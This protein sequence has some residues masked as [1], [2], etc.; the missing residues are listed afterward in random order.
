MRACI[1]ADEP[2]TLAGAREAAAEAGR[3]GL[4][5]ESA[6]DDGSRLEAGASILVFTGTPA[7]VAAAEESLIGLMAK[8]SG[9][10]T[11]AA[12]FV[13]RAGG[14]PEVVSGAWKKMPPAEKESVRRAVLLGGARFRICREPFVYL[15]KNYVEMLGGIRKSL[16]ATAGLGG[17]TRVIQLKGRYASIAEEACLAAESGADILSVD[18]GRLPDVELAA[19]A[20][21][22]RGLRGRVRIAFANGVRLAEMDAIKASDIDI[23]DVGREIVD[24]PLLDMRMEVLSVEAPESRR[25]GHEQYDLL[26]KTELTVRPVDLHGA[27]LNEIASAAAR[28]L[29]IEPDR[30]W[31][32]DVRDRALTIDVIKERVD[33]LGIVGRQNDLLAALGS[34]QGVTVSDETSVT[35]AGMLGWIAADGPEMRQALERSERMAVGMAERI[36]K[37]AVVFSTG[38]EVAS[39]Q[40]EDTNMRTIAE[41]LSARGYSVARGGVLADDRL[42]IAGRIRRAILDEGYGIVITTGGVGAEDKDHTVEAVLSLD[43]QA[44]APYLT[45]HQVGTG[46]HVKDG[47]RIV[48]GEYAGSLI[49]SLPGPNDEVAAALETLVPALD[50]SDGKQRLADGLAATLRARLR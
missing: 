17:R 27:N 37:R 39:G 23:I 34:L 29:G 1:L 6:L 21:R 41:A 49:V 7:Q 46:R 5:L 36:R 13:E 20:L 25:S 33:A 50:S 14:R 42:F 32:V 10:A 3:I 26:G 2:G 24:A 31:V 44:A 30:V 8:P 12:R 43:P 38:A 18:T 28:V 47:V 16:E 11:A 4:A 48:V 19:S 15:D 45:R 9:I 22:E 35:S 40:I